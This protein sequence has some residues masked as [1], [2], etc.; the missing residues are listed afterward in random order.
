MQ[1]GGAIDKFTLFFS[2]RNIGFNHVTYVNGMEYEDYD[3][4]IAEKSV[5]YFDFL[6]I[7]LGIPS[8]I[9]ISLLNFSQYAPSMHKNKNAKTIYT[10]RK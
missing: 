5:F 9:N 7:L 4:D 1:R 8:I 6:V 3:E 2:K 10:A